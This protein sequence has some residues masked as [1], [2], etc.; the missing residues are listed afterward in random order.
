MTPDELQARSR[1]FALRVI[2][3]IDA[4]PNTTAGRRSGD[5]LFRSATSVAANYRAARRARSLKEFIAKVGVVTEEADES[6]FWL[7]LIMDAGLLEADR[8]YELRREADE[9]TRIFASTRR[10]AGSR[11]QSPDHQITRSPNHKITK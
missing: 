3:L 11:R 8:V 9:L 1:E 4:L 7:G 6:E 2:R 10:T 5:Q